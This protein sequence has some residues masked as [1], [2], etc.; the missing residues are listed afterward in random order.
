MNAPSGAVRWKLIV[1]AVVVMP[2]TVLD[3]PFMYALAPMT[4]TK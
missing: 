3:F 2:G 4:L 1:L